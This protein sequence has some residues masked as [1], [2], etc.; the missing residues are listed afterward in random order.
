[1]N[2]AVNKGKDVSQCLVVEIFA[3]TGRL[4]PFARANRGHISDLPQ[5]S[6]QFRNPLKSRYHRA[7]GVRLRA[8]QP[9]SV[10]KGST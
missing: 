6:T 3:G 2:D 9:Q 10:L 5:T 4:M 7:E 8:V 1:M